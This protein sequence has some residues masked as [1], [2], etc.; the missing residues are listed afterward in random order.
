MSREPAKAR[1]N[2][3]KVEVSYRGENGAPVTPASLKQGTRFTATVKVSSL[4]A[5]RDLEQLA[6]SLRIPSGWEIVNERL[7]GGADAS[8]GY[9]HKDIRDDRVNWFFGLPASRY[10]T[11][12]VE[13]RAAYEGSY[14]MPAIVCGAMYEPAINASTEAGTA[15]VTR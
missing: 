2:G 13:L 15:V 12:T 6:L 5:G 11:F 8:E 14:S 4:L 9:D 1:G 10:K 7:T 3:L